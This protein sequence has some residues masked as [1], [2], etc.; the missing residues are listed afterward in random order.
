VLILA[1]AAAIAWANSP[2]AGAY[3]DL[4]HAELTFDFNFTVVKEDLRHLVNDGAMTLFFFVVGLEIK[5]ELVRGELSS[6]RKAALPAAAAL[7]GMA[8]PALIYAGVNYGSSGVQG[9]GIPMATD[10]AFAV[11]VLALAGPRVPT[12]LKVFLLAL[13]IVDDLGAIL[14]IAVFYTDSISTPALVW[15]GV[16][17]IGIVAARLTG[18]RSPLFF[19]IPACL[20]WLSVLESGIHA[21]LAGV[22]LAFLTPAGPIRS[23]KDYHTALRQL[24]EELEAA[25]SAGDREAQDTITADID[26]LTDEREPPLDQLERL[27]HPWTSFVVIPLFALANAGLDLSPDFASNLVGSTVGLGVLLGLV[28]GKPV[29][30]VLFSWLAVRIGWAALPHA[31]RWIDIAAVGMLAGIG[32][33]VALFISSLA[34]ESSATVDEAKAGIFV[35]SIVAGVIG[36]VAIRL[37]SN[38]SAG[39]PRLDS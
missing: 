8:V 12:S 29:G 31:T 24:F 9:W 39:S 7:G 36:L 21:T 5:R 22:V 16:V 14:V 25:E 2:W 32:F 6:P 3:D 18:I 30:I 37:G 34:F 13:A 26:S 33:T 15:A 1:A 4:W 20:L 28:V 27:L 38:R 23:R 19:V 35:A 11:G 10:I 17:L